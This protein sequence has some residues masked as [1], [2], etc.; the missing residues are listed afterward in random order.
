MAGYHWAQTEES[1]SAMKARRPEFRLRQNQFLDVFLLDAGI[2]IE[3]GAP[4][5]PASAET[6]VL[7]CVQARSGQGTI[8]PARQRPAS[9]RR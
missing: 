7:R 6:T 5:G 9:S 3:A 8:E 4:G 1:N 2:G